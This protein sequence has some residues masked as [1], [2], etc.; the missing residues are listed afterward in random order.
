M[1]VYRSAWN[2]RILV[3]A[4]P[5][6]DAEIGQLRALCD[7]RSFD[8]SYFPGIDPVRAGIYN[9]LP[10]VSFDEATVQNGAGPADAIMDEAVAL[11]AGAPSVHHGF[12]DLRPATFDRPFF[13]ATLRLSRLDR[14]LERIDLVPR[15]E[16]GTLI[17]VAVLLQSLGL[18]AVV[19]LLPLIRRG[20]ARPP[21]AMIGKSVVYFAALG[22]GFLFIEIHLIERAAFYLNDRSYAFALVLA[23]MLVFS[24]MGSLACGRYYGRPQRGVRLAAA[25][26]ALWC[27]AAWFLL[28]ALITST[29]GLSLALRICILLA[30]IA[31]VSFALGFPFPL[32]LTQFRGETD[33]F[34]PWAWSL[35]GAFSVISTPLANLIGLSAGLKILLLI[36]LALYLLV[37]LAFPREGQKA[38]A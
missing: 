13:F 29:L 12:F 27:I 30:V 34:L 1:I 32:G 5:W 22:I 6:S 38:P 37:S 20:A 2:A 33:A 36:A 16:I 8:V 10:V 3:S 11:L 35:N 25:A 31:P 4:A 19:L 28:P 7:E 21:A 24:G 23:G 15:E 17:N 26:I 14:I 9:D 18:A